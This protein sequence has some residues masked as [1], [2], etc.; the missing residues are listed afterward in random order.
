MP[1]K[2]NG[3]NMQYLIKLYRLERVNILN[4]SAVAREKVIG[5]IDEYFRA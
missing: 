5:L 2:N 4:L 3:Q 1:Y